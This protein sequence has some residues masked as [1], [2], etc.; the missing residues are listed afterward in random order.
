MYRLDI[1][2]SNLRMQYRMMNY[3]GCGPL[4]ESTRAL[5]VELPLDFRPTMGM[6]Y[7]VCPA[8]APV[9]VAASTKPVLL[10]SPPSKPYSKPLPSVSWSRSTIAGSASCVLLRPVLWPKVLRPDTKKRAAS[11]LLLL[12][13]DPPSTEECH[14][15][16]RTVVR[17]TDRQRTRFDWSRF[18]L[19]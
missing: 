8:C 11:Q 19:A 17:G 1:I 9:T 10:F 15:R 4:Y 16:R 14:R 5:N 7:Y 13:E 12:R 3:V 18:W 6:Y 2:H